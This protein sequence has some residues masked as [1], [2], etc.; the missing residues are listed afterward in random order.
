MLG[1]LSGRKLWLCKP[2]GETLTWVR[3]PPLA[4]F[5]LQLFHSSNEQVT[6]SSPIAGT[7]MQ[8]KLLKSAQ[9]FTIGEKFTIANIGLQP[10]RV[11]VRVSSNRIKVYITCGKHTGHT[12]S[13]FLDISTFKGNAIYTNVENT[14][15]FFLEKTK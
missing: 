8:P 10:R 14:D 4:P 2:V 13:K 6:D 12:R 9:Q 3:I 11:F 7:I 1:L 15:I 5:N